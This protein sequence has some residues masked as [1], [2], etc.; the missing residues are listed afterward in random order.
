[1]AQASSIARE[2]SMEEI[3]ASIRK[4]IEDSDAVQQTAVNVESRGIVAP[5]KRQEEPAAVEIASAEIVTYSSARPYAANQTSEVK[6][7]IQA[8]SVT[9]TAQA[10]MAD[11]DNEAGFKIFNDDQG[12]LKD[13]LPD[14]SADMDEVDNELPIAALDQSVS[15]E[16]LIDAITQL[17]EEPQDV[18][19]SAEKNEED[20]VEPVAQHVSAPI[21]QEPLVSSESEQRVAASFNNLAEALRAEQIRQLEEQAEALLQPLLKDWL[22]VNLAPMVERLVQEEIQRIIGAHKF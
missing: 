6:A 13:N 14:F 12:Y 18:V 3:L 16:A 8:E 20:A 2:P 15:E 4:I 10:N 21:M 22:D 17:I 19:Q 9:E 7:D 1:M 5:F 11:A